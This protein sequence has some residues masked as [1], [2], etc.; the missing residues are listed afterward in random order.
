MTAIH[1]RLPVPRLCRSTERP[2]L[3]MDVH[4][5]PS[6]ATASAAGARGS[7]RVATAPTCG[8]SKR[9]LVQGSRAQASTFARA[10]RAWIASTR[11]TAAFA[12]ATIIA[13]GSPTACALA[14]AATI[15][16]ACHV[17]PAASPARV[18]DSR[19]RSARARSTASRLR[20]VAGKPDRRGD[21]A[22]RHG[23]DRCSASP[24]PRVARSMQRRR[25]AH[26]RS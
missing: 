1:C 12:P 20:V 4:S 22:L 2:A 5:P 16:A 8:T 7:L 17:D 9:P 21:G 14:A 25:R 23:E 11:S 3:S 10:R 15:S 26:R 19:A 6:A 13:L 24:H 18:S